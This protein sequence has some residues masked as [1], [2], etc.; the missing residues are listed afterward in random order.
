[1]FEDILIAGFGVIGTEILY[2]IV[3]KIDK[4]KLNISIIEK[5]YSNFPGGVAYG[6]SIQSMVFLIIHLDYQMMSFKIGLK[7]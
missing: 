7:R 2:Q 3:K 6:K 1:M 4:R 5:D